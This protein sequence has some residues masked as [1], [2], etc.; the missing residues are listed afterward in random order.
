MQLISTVAV[1]HAYYIGHALQQEHKIT[2]QAE[3]QNSC[4]HLAVLEA[5]LYVM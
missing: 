2:I 4:R 3:D 1:F 5:G